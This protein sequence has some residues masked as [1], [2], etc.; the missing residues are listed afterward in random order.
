MGS[1]FRQTTEKT[2]A[3]VSG[4]LSSKFVIEIDSVN[5]SDGDSW[6]G[7]VNRFQH[8][9]DE[10]A[11]GLMWGMYM[12]STCRIDNNATGTQPTIADGI[13]LAQNFMVNTLQTCAW[14]YGKTTIE[15]LT[16]YVSQ[17]AS[18]LYRTTRTGGWI[19]GEGKSYYLDPYLANRIHATA[20][21]G[22]NSLPPTYS[23]VTTGATGTFTIA[24][25]RVVASVAATFVAADVNRTIRL[26]GIDLQIEAFVNGTTVVVKTS[27]FLANFGPFPLYKLNSQNI[28]QANEIQIIWK[29]PLHCFR[30]QKVIPC[31]QIQ[32]ELT[33]VSASQARQ[34]CIESL[35]VT[36]ATTAVFTHIRTR[37]YIPVGEGPPVPADATYLMDID[38]IQVQ[39]E[40]ITGSSQVQKSYTSPKGM[41]A[42][43]VGWQ[44]ALAGTDTRYPLSKFRAWNAGATTSNLEQTI[45]NFQLQVGSQVRPRTVW[46]SGRPATVAGSSA[47]YLNQFYNAFLDETGLSFA[48]DNSGE[49]FN[50][51][52][53]NGVLTHWAFPRD[54]IESN[55]DVRLTVQFGQVLG[56]TNMLVFF[57]TKKIAQVVIS[58]RR[59]RGVVVQEG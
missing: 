52:L 18:V 11:Q 12:L 45:N 48:T 6:F 53:D 44:T 33:P 49:S 21:D 32:I 50:D 17:M 54:N 41:H 24:D 42:I 40:N 57:H 14:L 39:S 22:Q 16:Q 2:L 19:S 26:N 29:P 34:R 13:A 47:L 9:F 25:S 46:E 28:L 59:V 31:G 58:N 43:T 37:L 8:E 4:G 56:D 1:V 15:S 23:L 35:G 7:S 3:P 51:W 10:K 30:A 36:T 55:S 20:S 27:G 5:S 38:S